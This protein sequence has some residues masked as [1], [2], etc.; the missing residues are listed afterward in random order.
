MENS[1]RKI[2]PLT[3][4]N[5]ATSVRNTPVV[6]NGTYSRNL[7]RSVQEQRQRKI[8]EE[9][10]KFANDFKAGNYEDYPA[11]KAEAER[12]RKRDEERKRKER[13]ARLEE[14]RASEKK[15]KSAMD[16]YESKRDSWV[17]SQINRNTKL[18]D[19]SNAVG[20]GLSMLNKSV[21][22]KPG[23][24]SEDA[25][26]GILNTLFALKNFLGA[27]A[28]GSDEG[29][30]KLTIG[31]ISKV[32]RNQ[33][34]AQ[35]H[36][37]TL[38]IQ[39]SRQEA[40]DALND[41][42]NDVDQYGQS[43]RY[44][45]RTG[46]IK[47]LSRQI[48]QYDNE[49]NSLKDL[50]DLYKKTYVG[51]NKTWFL[52][53]INDTWKGIKNLQLKN[54]WKG[55]KELAH[56]FGE[57]FGDDLW[58]GVQDAAT[59][60]NAK[61]YTRQRRISEIDDE[62]QNRLKEKGVKTG[63]ERAYNS[64][65]GVVLDNDYTREL[66]DIKAF[67]DQ[68]E[69]IL[70]SLSKEASEKLKQLEETKAKWNVSSGYKALIEAYQNG[71][72]FDLNYIFSEYAQMF[73]YSMSSPAQ[74]AATGIRFGALVGAG[75]A[76]ATGNAWAA[77][78]LM[79]ITEI[80]L[81]PLDIAGA[82]HEN[83][84][85]R[86]EKYVSNIESYI[87]DSANGGEQTFDRIIGDLK[88]QAEEAYK[89]IGLSDKQV[90]DRLSGSDAISNLLAD[91]SAGIIKNEDPI[92]KAALL[93]ANRGLDAQQDANN[94]RT[95]G[96]L[97]L[98][99]SLVWL[100]VKAKF[101]IGN[102]AAFAVDRAAERAISNEVK[103]AVD[104]TAKKTLCTRIADQGAKGA[105]YTK[106]DVLDRYERIYG[107]PY[108]NGTLSGSLKKG[109]KF[110]VEA[111]VAMGYGMAGQHLLGAT[112]AALNSAAHLARTQL[113]PSAQKLLA[114][115]ERFGARK[116][117]LVYDKI[118]KN[119]DF[120]KLA[121]I[122][123]YK[124]AKVNT[125]SALNEG[126]EEAAQYI[127]EN[128]R[129]LARK[130]GWDGMSLGDLIA[131][132]ISV[133][134]EI[135]NA[136]LAMLG[137]GDSP[138]VDDARFWA[139]LNGG[140]ML[141]FTNQSAL[142]NAVVRGQQDVV[143]QYKVDKVLTNAAIVNRELDDRDRAAY[144]DVA[145]QVIG[146]NTQYVL[147]Y[148]DRVESE[149]SR[150]A[151]RVVSQE[152]VNKTR[153]AVLEIAAIANSKEIRKQLEESGI[154][155]GS[156]RYAL[157][158][159]DQYALRN[160]LQ[161][162][163]EQRQYGLGERQQVYNSAEFNSE[164]D[165][166]VKIVNSQNDN[167][168]ADKEAHAKRAG[169]AAVKKA[170]E[171]RAKAQEIASQQVGEEYS[172]YVALTDEER[173][174]A[175]MSDQEFNEKLGEIRTNAENL[176]NDTSDSLLREQLVKR[177]K[178]INR[179]TGL[180]ELKAK[181][182]TINGFFDFI[183]DNLKLSPM[184][185]DA[186][187]IM[188]S[189]DE[190]IE[191][192]KK[193]LKETD[194]AYEKDGAN[195]SEKETLEYLQSGNLV[196]VSAHG[197]IAKQIE[198][199][200]AVLTAWGRVVFNQMSTIGSDRYAKRIEAIE[201]ARENN[202][203]L[204][205]MVSEIESGDAVTRL[206]KQFAKEDAAKA[207]KEQK[208][209]NKQTAGP[210]FEA[211]TTR[212]DGQKSNLKNNKE[213]FNRRREAAKQRKIGRRNKY[214][215]GGRLMAGIP[216][217]N[218]FLDIA[219]ELLY[220]A[221]VGVYKFAEFASDLKE[222][223]EK[224]GLDIN[225]YIND[226]KQFY[227]RFRAKAPNEIKANLDS[228]PEVIKY[229]NPQKPPVEP[230]GDQ[231]SLTLQQKIQKQSENILHD[232]SSHFDI[233]YDD[234]TN[235][236]IY[237]N[238]E[239]VKYSQYESNKNV[240]DITNELKAANTS[241][242]A[243]EQKLSQIAERYPGFPVQQFVA[244][245]NV[246]GIE[247]AIARKLMSFS[248][249]TYVRTGVMV[250][251]AV[252]AILVGSDAEGAREFFGTSYDVFK[253]QINKVKDELQGSLSL[254]S[255]PDYIL[256]TDKDGKN[257]A[258][259]A[260]MVFTDE[261]GAIYIIDV[262]STVYPSVRTHYEYISKKGFSIKDQVEDTLKEADEALKQLSGSYAKGLYML[263]IVVS[264][265][266]TGAF[267][268][269]NV[270]IE[271]D[272]DG[273]ALFQVKDRPNP[274]LSN[275]LDELK[276][277][278]QKIVDQ[279]NEKISQYNE[280]IDQ[281]GSYNTKYSR[282]SNEVFVEQ[283]S[284]ALYD[285][286]I[287]NLSTELEQIQDGIQQLNDHVASNITSIS[288]DVT[289][290]LF[291]NI[292]EK[293]INTP[294]AL[295]NLKECAKEL[296][297]VYQQVKDSGLLLIVPS[298]Y[299]EHS[300]VDRF[301]SA[302]I[303]TQTALD[304][305][306]SCEESAGY[307]FTS[308]CTLIAAAMQDIQKRKDIFGKAGIQVKNWWINNF[309]YGVK[310]NTTG[311]IT[312][313]GEQQFAFL[314][315]LNAWID[316]FMYEDDEKWKFKP[317]LV[318]LLDDPRNTDLRRLYSSVMHN[319]FGKLIDNFKAAIKI[320]Q[321]YD[322]AYDSK[323]AFAEYMINQFDLLWGTETDQDITNN[324]EDFVQRLNNLSIKW[325]D[326]YS[327][328]E[329]HSPA[330]ASIPNDG[331]SMATSKFYYLM[332][333][334]PGFPNNC[335]VELEVKN[336][337]LRLWITGPTVDGTQRSI[338]L[339]FLSTPYP[340][341]TP[342]DARRMQVVN[343]GNLKFI[344]KAKE[345]LEYA[346]THPE[347]TVRFDV[348]T[349]KGSIRYD[350]VNNPHNVQDWLMSGKDLYTIK[351]SKKDGIG[352]L[353]VTSTDN[354]GK[355]YYV[356]GGDQLRETV[357]Q[358]DDEF[359][360]Q[361]IN[362]NSGA[363]V[364]FRGSEGNKIGVTI[365]PVQIGVDRAR[366]IADLIAKKASGILQQNGFSIDSM[367]QLMLY[368][369]DPEGR[370]SKYN[371]LRALVQIDGPM[372]TIGQNEP[373]N[374]FSQKSS[375]IDL[376]AGLN[377]V[378]DAE[379]LNSSIQ[380]S[381][382]Q[383]LQV[384]KQ[385]V[386]RGASYVDLPI[387]IRITAEDVVHQNAVGAN[388]TTWLGYMLRNG[389]L[390]T[391]AIGEGFKQIN[392][393]NLRLENKELESQSSTQ[394]VPVQQIGQPRRTDLDIDAMF[395]GLKMVVPED[396][397][398][399][400]DS[401]DDITTFSSNVDSYFRQV[402]G[403][404]QVEFWKVLEKGVIAK[405]PT[406]YVVGLCTTDLMMLSRYAPEEAA[407]H[408]AFHRVIELLLTEEERQVFYKAYSDKFGV[409]DDRMIAEGLA[410]LFV[411]F[412]NKVGMPKGGVFNKIKRFFR[413]IAAGIVTTRKLGLRNT[414]NLF[415]F[416]NDIN[417]GKY[418]K[419]SVSEKNKQRFND[420]FGGWL[421]YTVKN[422]KTGQ[423]FEAEHIADSS[424]LNSLIKSIGYYIAHSLGYD[425]VV[426]E[427]I[428]YND[429][430]YIE[431]SIISGTFG[432]KF[433]SKSKSRDGVTIDESLLNLIPYDILEQLRG[434]NVP[435]DQLTSRQRAFREIL[436]D[437]NIGAVSGHIANY[438]GD[439]IG[440]QARGKIEKA[441]D[442]RD[443]NRDDFGENKDPQNLNI[444]R[445]DKASYEFSKLASVSNQVKL[446]FA[447]IPYKTFDN[448]GHL[449][450]DLSVNP[451]GTPQYMPLEEVYSILENDLSDVKS[452]DE[453]YDKLKKL[454]INSA[455]HRAVFAKFH[456]L[457]YGDSTTKGIYGTDKFGN[458]VC[459]DYNREALAIQIVS[460]LSSQKIDF[461]VALSESLG[462]E[463]GKDIRIS[464]SSLERD[465]K[466]MPKQWGQ[467]LTSGQSQVF[468]QSRDK[469]GNLQ[470]KDRQRHTKTENTIAEVISFL[471][472]VREALTLTNGIVNING[473]NY[474]KDSVDGISAIKQELVR[475]LHQMG[476]MISDKAFDY[477]LLQ[478]F[479]DQGANGLADCL[480]GV[481]GTDTFKP[482]SIN[483]FIQLLDS[484][485]DGAGNIQESAI[486]KGYPD[487]GF[488]KQ[489]ATWQ[490]MYNRITVQNMALGL[491]GKQLFSISQNSA[492]SHIIDALNSGDLNNDVVKTLMKFNYNLSGGNIPI[493][494]I[495]LRSIKN[496]DLKKI[497]AHTYIG[498]K[499]DNFGD[500]GSEYTDA[501]EIDD[502]IAKLTMLQEG[503]M[504]FPTLADK[505][506]WLVLKGVKIPGMRLIT[507]RKGKQKSVTCEN[508]VQVT[509][510][511]GKPYIMPSNDAID[512]MIEYAYTER[513]AIMQCMED[514]KTMPDNAKIKNYHTSRKDGVEPNGTRFLQLSKVYI[515]E[516]G[517]LV[518][519]NL[520]N[521][522]KSSKDMLAD[523]NT[524]F[525]NQPLEVQR[526]IMGLTLAVQAEHEVQKAIDLGLVE[527]YSLNQNWKTTDGKDVN[528]SFDSSQEVL[529]NLRSRHLS[530]LQ[531]DAVA[532]E[533]LKQIP[534][535]DPNI[536]TWSNIPAD[537]RGTEKFAKREMVNGLAVAA[538][539]ADATFR[540]IISSQEVLRCFAGHPGMFKV[541]Y[542]ETGIKNSTADI[543]KRLGGLISTG[544]DNIQNIPGIP[545]MYT[546]AELA[547][548]EI[549]SRSNVAKDLKNMF[550]T[551]QVRN[552][553]ALLT[554]NWDEVYQLSKDQILEQ[555]KD[556]PYKAKIEK[557]VSDG[558]Q[559]AAMFDGGIN[560]ADGAAY[561]TDTMCENLLRMRGAYG[562]EVKEAFDILRSEEAY[563]WKKS[564]EAY[565]T[566]YDAVNLVTTKYTAYGFRGH[567]VN[568]QEYS[569]ISVPYYNKYALF[570]L[571][572]CIASGKMGSIYQKMLDE[573]VDML[574]LTSAV[575]VGSCGAVKFNGDEIVGN[576]NKY[577]QDF[578]YLRRQ[579]NTDPEE[580]E[581]ITMGTQM[582]K[583][584]LQNL[585]GER[586][587]VDSRTGRTVTGDEI[588]EDMMGA[589]NN[590]SK[591]GE[592]EIIEMFSS[593]GGRTVDP[594][595]LANYLQEQLT[596]R[597]A[598]K[599]L[600]DLIRPYAKNGKVNLHALSATA[601]AS[602]I[603]SILIST[604]NKHVIDITT[605]GASYVQRSVFAMDAKDGEG[606]IQGDD[607]MS[608]DINGGR[609]LQMLNDD[610]SMD[611][612]ISINFF[613][614]LFKGKNMSFEEKRRFL[615]KNG[616][617][618][619]DAK[620][621]IVAYRIPTQ[622]QSSIHA[623]H[624]ADVI[625]AVKDTIIL[626]E[627]FTR[628]TGSDFDIDHLYLA[629]YNYRVDKNGKLSNWMEKGTKKYYQNKLLGN[630]ITLLTDKNS[631]N[632][633]YKSIDSDVELPK[634]CSKQ[635][636]T[637]ESLEAEPYNFGTLRAQVSVKND[638]TSGKVSIGPFA[639]N[640]TSH[641]LTS[642]YNVR[643]RPTVVTNN[644]KIKGFNYQLD[645]DGNFIS[646]WLSGYISGAVDNAKDPFLAK[647]N[648]NQ[649]T[650]NMLNLLLRSGFGETA[651]WFCAQPIVRDMS[652]ANERSKSQYAKD[653]SHKGSGLS[654]KEFAI[655]EAIKKYV[656]ESSLTA[657]A[658][659]KWTSSTQK[660]DLWDRVR[661]INWVEQNREL[662][663]AFA[664]D[665]TLQTTT[666]DG[667]TYE[668]EYVQQ[669]V[670]N[671]WK[672]LEKYAIALG[673]L[674]Q[675]T[676]IDTRKH[677]KSIIEINRYLD[678][679][680]DIF[681][682]IEPETSI[683]DVN[684]LQDFARR[685]WIEQK[686]KAAI[687]LPSFVLQNYTFSAN[688]RFIQAVLDFGH[689]ITE[690]GEQLSSDV[691]NKISRHLQT[692]V[693]SKYFVD[694]VSDNLLTKD[695]DGNPTETTDQHIR[696]LF[697]GKRSMA[698]RLTGLKLAIELNPQYKRL[699]NNGLIKQLYTLTKE[700]PSVLH[701]ELT[702]HP[703][704]IT[705]LDSVDSSKLNSDLLID[706][707]EDLLTD[708][709][710]YVRAFAQDLIIYAFMTSGEFKGWSKLFKYVPASWITGELN[711]SYTSYAD[712]IDGVLSSDH[713]YEQY[714]DDIASNCFSDRSI[715]DLIPFKNQDG[716]ENF[717]DQNTICKIGRTMDIAEIESSKP[718]IL[719]KQDQNGRNTDAYSLYKRV[720]FQ[721]IGEESVRPVYIRIKKKGYSRKSNNV[722]EY[723]WDFQY[724]GNE[725]RVMN[726]K[727]NISAAVEAL[728]ESDY[729]GIG[730]TSQ[731]IQVKYLQLA[732]L[733]QE[734]APS[735][736]RQ[737]PIN[738]YWGSNDNSD[739]SNFAY[740]P[741][742]LGELF[743]G[744]EYSEAEA[745]INDAEHSDEDFALL[746]ESGEG[747][748]SSAE[749][750]QC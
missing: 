41:I 665:P 537:T 495:I 51:E 539:L 718:Y 487:N 532:S 674:V 478:G 618:G 362:T 732:K 165:D 208:K 153:K 410:D 228:A 95:M 162:I 350:D 334:V 737:Q 248:T 100:P 649:F 692:A 609:R 21:S 514:L 109:Y 80:G 499:T 606:S 437:E 6:E 624:V 713:D 615:I 582:I 112:G 664:T 604:V 497:T 24:S 528:V 196:G 577:E 98:Q 645:D 185:P 562:N 218:V 728:S 551:A 97:L 520:N 171:A 69:K 155:Y 120:A 476:I 144:V 455:M 22:F 571:F 174:Y 305:A 353:K 274:E 611:C 264:L 612:V 324:P 587:Y 470:F 693:K 202:Q 708:S 330:Y 479:G 458:I 181:F 580:G 558:E 671:A 684:G 574:M 66:Q 245:R 442:E 512:Q 90:K 346:K 222:V 653:Q 374:I 265:D 323:I 367:L 227:I 210:S 46:E 79:N 727:Y 417:N 415:A 688:P 139:N 444:D 212:T 508:P 111:G 87:K 189:L 526:R 584:C 738:V 351:L 356:Y 561:I 376:L 637:K 238:K 443:L 683:W 157:A 194:S 375:I 536:G 403:D 53:G 644:T 428:N 525:F 37:K 467:I 565:K 44:G 149:E 226:A 64:P 246:D 81:T 199:E 511:G 2:S 521:P 668:R 176:V 136:Y 299:D 164:I 198:Q 366:I 483:S 184:R 167:Y 696:N 432:G 530:G 163:Q 633:T 535:K 249:N 491:N 262:R 49:L 161:N 424:E 719:V 234:G 628:I 401:E 364:Y 326:L 469:D 239:A 394:A 72:M 658:L 739:L 197:K 634:G 329:Q 106:K 666:V 135:M 26:R 255:T 438:I 143:K 427:L 553:Y 475:R 86:A 450:E 267:R 406:G 85:E 597:N 110:G 34:A 724:R 14:E 691:A 25:S 27:G 593:D 360:K 706:G 220:A 477:M 630:M 224:N 492:I 549:A 725:N 673:G 570:P 621:N 252:Q 471:Q 347:Y 568:G 338:W 625:P 503:Y 68:N 681:N 423:K 422:P 603:E 102:K 447:T 583:I 591:I 304:I 20:T 118:L 379:I 500:N 746:N 291:G 689:M 282:I 361:K 147:N 287:R 595:K 343:R 509:F 8:L 474:N 50:D 578:G 170:K 7:K 397:V 205:W 407:W 542:T 333:T 636:Q 54:V 221:E 405:L 714:F 314:N 434:D 284:S 93:Y 421:A 534:D 639:L 563:D 65:L 16:L 381:Q 108:K 642:H 175:Q 680:N 494:S 465:A 258:A 588:L 137:I 695:K 4:E 663:K 519:K 556:T 146:N 1:K 92:L 459:N 121:L 307:D 710:K 138:Y 745:I 244:Y 602:W 468:A 71:S 332:S 484:I 592:D 215:K 531:I 268:A 435:E 464:S 672:S 389:L 712:Y 352:I 168:S 513:E 355:I 544:E 288:V 341:I 113:S 187:T 94:F 211:P 388:G 599:V 217:Q 207:R 448:E 701:G 114:Q 133:G 96:D 42:Y 652:A 656:P 399:V 201:K 740:R 391:R 576:F 242:Q 320:D 5:D 131:N 177:A 105:S 564:R 575:K 344:D 348:S 698:K 336:G 472:T 132:D 383:C 75:A 545:K 354:N 462:D 160:Q 30:Y 715:V 99:K 457:V 337:E 678:G 585:I 657:Q 623:L 404:D 272:K 650:Y 125:L 39:Q 473:K 306:L 219:N 569:S 15:Q 57:F 384:V 676:K 83:Y 371:N 697:V 263:P 231:N 117:Q 425:A 490:G 659:K 303:D 643:F 454:A 675:H 481:G 253:N 124:Q 76:V 183:H 616:I 158:I 614:D 38:E 9:R 119:R 461:I 622:A 627:E 486:E 40:I 235:K 130:Y 61:E 655:M 254:I 677:G 84:Q 260:D 735:P 733:H 276:Q 523:A 631:I 581:E 151:A 59:W 716:T 289:E 573:D 369:K 33:G 594:Q 449:I 159:A 250:R 750:E 266:K 416:F 12:Q 589:I 402:F 166:Q 18:S 546:C 480:N 36:R 700:D 328:S 501:A 690:P 73:G 48:Q 598:N 107:T 259:L 28:T 605:P 395:T 13:Q 547:D 82:Q 315:Q 29:D 686:T 507:N 736:R 357:G 89:K 723:G 281:A 667:V 363:I 632:T 377:I 313:I 541:E 318:A 496:G 370:V 261:S 748:S 10:Q 392:I 572:K 641:M 382:L 63:V 717:I 55:T 373:L 298:T 213:E 101:S 726:E 412:M 278:A 236:R 430:Q 702:E 554:G 134:G 648:T 452:I 463:N 498:L 67:E 62:Y 141:G 123:G 662:L 721:H 178:A 191:F 273:K 590:L 516:N 408:E 722:Y 60:D 129:S 140:A 148:L 308:E 608:K 517:K 230:S 510:V 411:D 19:V 283:E 550:V 387:G 331:R 269:E 610:G 453:L 506:T 322:G 679:Y 251:N 629:R 340:G 433:K 669:K 654:R 493:G 309:A 172:Q 626:P 275:N 596:S 150:R 504:L 74:I 240:L 543:Q 418:R 56:S 749:H 58:E 400:R 312:S 505:G 436:T 707:W 420:L 286:Y 192:A 296:D 104:E 560:V 23:F 152:D 640:S 431:S 17:N 77:A 638:F 566:I 302:I 195:M 527:R 647:L 720:G 429:W 325:R 241:D 173:S 142:V 116:Y 729:I 440:V 156:E 529:W 225:E 317:E 385:M 540:H 682:P 292:D 579:L 206:E 703:E 741:F 179:L 522:K 316:T 203:K 190:Q 409:T 439:L 705:V 445:Y 744:P 3:Q 670:F 488:I 182:N 398:V 301:I 154:E 685:T 635:I 651:V 279:I 233:I 742:T 70:E 339:P 335:K 743:T 466:S 396:G 297:A 52:D 32:H 600:L 257:C 386:A 128:D 660:N 419:R 485:V 232:I 734:D 280:L 193:E 342:K 613:D 223:A 646:A 601:D 200:N 747:Q 310:N 327:D 311:N 47:E 359:R 617:I 607:N 169:D 426:P 372:V 699:A 552:V 285:V 393:S 294:E 559:F 460:A 91:V 524:Y 694:Y 88:S 319:G 456:R 115:V 180:L 619:N 489:L 538:I 414:R 518:G 390:Q 533:L 188:E 78:P 586:S 704:F 661:A 345:L 555:V 321:Q 413:T 43:S 730:E 204:N 229:F 482:Q 214:R 247:E 295:E 35:A 186:K 293:L 271:Y 548:Y 446:F 368:M 31:E 557:A 126:A 441:A 122:Y 145:R 216:F 349:N 127:H 515:E 256:Y 270:T 502:Y 11:L 711:P 45:D 365:E 709:D 358:F 687:S 300:L 277:S 378:T 731:S 290:R 380:T 620:A 237:T 209:A 451:N 567:T 243:F 103:L